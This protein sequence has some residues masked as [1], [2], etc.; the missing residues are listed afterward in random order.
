MKKSIVLI[1]IVAVLASTTMVYA[2]D[3]RSASGS[4]HFTFL[5]ELR[6]FSFSAHTTK[7]GDVIGQAQ[8]HNRATG[9]S[10]HLALNCMVDTGHYALVGGVVS[11]SKDPDEIGDRV[12]FAVEDN[13]EGSR[14]QPD[15]ITG[16][17]FLPPIAEIPDC[18]EPP[19]EPPLVPIEKG[20]IQL[21]YK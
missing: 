19:L 7:E 8:A 12:V 2:S 1:W 15:R 10:Y 5:G 13:G 11:K 3:L 6:T 16:L 21:K 14:S 9:S 17:F 18:A 20:N 4:G